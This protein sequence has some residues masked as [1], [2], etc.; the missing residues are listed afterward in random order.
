MDIIGWGMA[1]GLVVLVMPLL[2]FI[3]IVWLISKVVE[4]VAPS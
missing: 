1:L 2:P 3:I 4:R